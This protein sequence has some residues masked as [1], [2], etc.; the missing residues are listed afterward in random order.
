MNDEINL[1]I[2]FSDKEKAMN[3]YKELQ[4]TLKKASSLKQEL[5]V[6]IIGIHQRD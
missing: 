5:A 2:E 4:D 1:D 6:M 3:I